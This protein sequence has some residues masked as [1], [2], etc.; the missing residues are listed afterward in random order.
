[1]VFFL[2]LFSFL[3]RFLTCP[4]VLSGL[5]VVLPRHVCLL[6]EVGFGP[7]ASLA[8]WCTLPWACLSSL[9]VWYFVNGS[10]ALHSAGFTSPKT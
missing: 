4:F 2:S 9:C 7:L 6:G 8:C 10:S 3:P 5:G 1:M